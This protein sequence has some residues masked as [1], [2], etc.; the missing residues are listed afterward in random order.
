MFQYIDNL[1]QKPDKQKKRVA[2]SLAFIF[3]LV[4]FAFWYFTV[5]PDF[6]KQ[7]EVDKK[8]EK[9]NNGPTTSFMSV[10]S[11]KIG[12]MQDQLAKIKD[13]AGS[14]STGSDYYISTSTATTTES[15]NQEIEAENATT[16]SNNQLN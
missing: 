15:F 2:F 11:G 8:E 16:S 6:K 9:L 4:I 12:E 5:I 13:F 14:F 1:R 7:A 10:F 3:C